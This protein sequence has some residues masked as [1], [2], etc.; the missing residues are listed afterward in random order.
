MGLQAMVC[1]LLLQVIFSQ[2][3]PLVKKEFQSS[4]LI[5]RTRQVLLIRFWRCF[6]I[7]SSCKFHTIPPE[8]WQFLKTIYT[9]HARLVTFSILLVLHGRYRSLDHMVSLYDLDRRSLKWWKK[10][11][12]PNFDVC[13]NKCFGHV[14][15]T[16]SW[17]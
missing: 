12:L 6:L 5:T 8:G 9:S 15:P 7:I 1:G 11:C 14:P 13:C 17:W 3:W 2:R 4:T 16:A 10:T